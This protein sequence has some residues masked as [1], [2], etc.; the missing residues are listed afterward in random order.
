[1][2]NNLK[3]NQGEVNRE[4]LEYFPR[5][6]PEATNNDDLVFDFKD[7]FTSIDTQ[8]IKISFEN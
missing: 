1:M 3:A 7:P 2:E 6:E 4:T 8:I 5:N